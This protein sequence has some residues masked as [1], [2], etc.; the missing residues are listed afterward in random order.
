MLLKVPTHSR[1]SVGT[2]AMFSSPIA[3]QSVVQ[4]S[5]AR[6]L[7]AFGVAPPHPGKGVGDSQ[8]KWNMRYYIFQRVKY[9][10]MYCSNHNGQYSCDK[11]KPQIKSNQNKKKNRE[12][13]KFQ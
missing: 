8:V 11:W 3:K 1:V 13:L 2:H 9:R 10:F 4:S 6:Q 7:L 5:Q 12:I